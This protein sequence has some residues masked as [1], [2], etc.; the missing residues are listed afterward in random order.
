MCPYWAWTSSYTAIGLC[1]PHSHRWGHPDRSAGSLPTSSPSDPSI[2]PRVCVEPSPYYSSMLHHNHPLE[3]PT[4]G[5]LLLPMWHLRNVHFVPSG[6]SQEGTSSH[7]TQSC[8][9]THLSSIEGFQVAMSLFILCIIDRQEIICK[10]GMRLVHF[11][12][13][14]AD[15]PATSSNPTLPPTSLFPPWLSCHPA[16][17]QEWSSGD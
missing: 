16:T 13:M 9:K 12:S 8:L 2:H 5:L 3:P 17:I 7:S 15:Q 6:R 4:Q 10:R 11:Y 1:C 14:G